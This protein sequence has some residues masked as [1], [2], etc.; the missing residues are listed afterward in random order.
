MALHEFSQSTVST[1][2]AAL[3]YFGFPLIPV[4][5]N[6]LNCAGVNR[7]RRNV[8]S[9]GVFARMSAFLAELTSEKRTLSPE[10]SSRAAAAKR[11][12]YTP[13]SERVQ[14]ITGL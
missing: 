4:S 2:S 10:V 1:V 5:R 8:R 6:S 7:T 3:L 14:S 9:L 12:N 11:T 13:L